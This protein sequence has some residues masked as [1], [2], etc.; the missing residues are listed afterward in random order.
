MVGMGILNDLC[1]LGIRFCR[2]AA[3]TTSRLYLL[4]CRMICHFCARYLSIGS[5]FDVMSFE[6]RRN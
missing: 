3:F 2:G 5:E 6:L 1:L 4:L